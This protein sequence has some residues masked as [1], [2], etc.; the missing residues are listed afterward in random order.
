MSGTT[1]T[2]QTYTKRDDRL[3]L[4]VVLLGPPPDLRLPVWCGA[5]TELL[6]RLRLLESLSC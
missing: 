1:R 2:F 4:D 6:A 5:F 3:G